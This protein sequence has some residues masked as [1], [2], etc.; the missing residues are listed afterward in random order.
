MLLHVGSDVKVE[1]NNVRKFLYVYFF[2][3]CLINA[4]VHW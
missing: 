2:I 4:L 3:S 1:D